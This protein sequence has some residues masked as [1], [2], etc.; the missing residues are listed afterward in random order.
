MAHRVE[1]DFTDAVVLDVLE[2]RDEVVAD[3]CVGTFQ[4]DGVDGQDDHEGEQRDHE[5]LRDALDAF[6]DAE[7]ADGEAEQADEDGPE[8]QFQGVAQHF[9]EPSGDFLGRFADERSGD[10][11]EAVVHHPAGDGGVIHHEQG[12][13]DDGKPA[14]PV[15]F[16]SLR[17]EDVI[18]AGGTSLRAAA[19]R[20][21]G[22]QDG[23]AEDDQEQKVDEH[24]DGAAVLPADVRELPDVA[25]ADRAAGRDQ[26]V[27]ESG[28]EL[29]TGLIVHMRF[30]LFL[31]FSKS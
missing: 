2:V 28:A 12:T 14:V 27:T 8:G 23:D 4:E 31:N 1:D 22:G 9:A 29:L 25:D 3:A 15:P 20:K 30:S 21:L 19:D 10:V 16:G 18:G 17:F 11:L 13:A 24:E 26:D 7:V 6:L 5:V